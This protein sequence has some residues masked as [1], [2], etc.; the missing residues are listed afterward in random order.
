MSTARYSSS[1]TWPLH[2]K[3]FWRKSLGKARKK[4]WTLHYIG[5]KHT[6][7]AVMCPAG[8]HAFSVDQTARNSEKLATEASKTIDKCPCRPVS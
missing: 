8:E 1:D 4:S 5:S 7:G 6:F 3:K 2:Q